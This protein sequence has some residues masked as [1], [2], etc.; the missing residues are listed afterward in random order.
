M[1]VNPRTHPLPGGQPHLLHPGHRAAPVPAVRAGPAQCA[2][3]QE[4]ARARVHRRPHGHRRDRGHPF[5]TAGPVG[6]SG[7]RPR[8]CRG[9]RPAG[10]PGPVP[11][12]GGRGRRRRTG[13]GHERVP[14]RQGRCQL[15]HRDPRGHD[16]D[17]R[18]RDDPD[19]SRTGSRHRPVLRCLHRPRHLRPLVGAAGHVH[20][21]AHRHLH[22]RLAHRP[23]RAVY[24]SARAATSTPSVAMPRRRDCPV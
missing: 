1:S 4:P 13:R 11:G 10:T 20:H 17:T 16:R 3:A 6:R 12:R 7:P 15:V 5:R 9:H 8:R 21:P 24:A 14:R 2:S 22:R 19:R 18:G 23:L